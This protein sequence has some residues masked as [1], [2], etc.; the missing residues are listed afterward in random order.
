[1]T[2]N[3]FRRRR[4]GV[5]GADAPGDAHFEPESRFVKMR[6]YSRAMVRDDGCAKFLIE[7]AVNNIIVPGFRYEPEGAT[8]NS[9]WTCGCH[10]SARTATAPTSSGSSLRPSG[11]SGTSMVAAL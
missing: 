1:M 9:A 5:N 8:R 4:N 3:R 6:E 11:I 2:E 10:Y 7:R